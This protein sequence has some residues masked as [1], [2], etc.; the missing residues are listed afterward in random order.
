ML[1]GKFVNAWKER[2]VYS[3]VF[4]D[5]VGAFNNVHHK[6]LLHNLKKRRISN[7]MVKWIGN[8]LS[9]RYTQMCFNINGTN[10]ERIKTDAGVPRGSPISP[11]L[12]HC[13]SAGCRG[14]SLGFIDDIAYGVQGES[15][16][17]NARELERMLMKVE[18]WRKSHGARFETTKYVLAH[19]TRSRTEPTANITIMGTTIEPSQEVQYLRVIFD[20]K[21]HYGQYIQH[22]ARKGTRFALAISRITKSTWGATYQ[23]LRML[24]N[25]VAVPRMDYTTIVWHRPK[26][27]GHKKQPTQLLK[28]ET[29]QRTA[30]KAILGA[31]HTALKIEMALHPPHLRI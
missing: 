30:M 9:D 22:V 31:F 13:G 19:F 21:L 14:L 2:D 1:S 6:Q 4:M 25:S 29:A 26:K 24:F 10:T 15:D 11:I 23:Q 20:G 7:F 17:H 12:Y 5:V 27:E 16:V 28:I 8:F 18:K 3:G